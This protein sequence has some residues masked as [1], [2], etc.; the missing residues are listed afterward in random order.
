MAWSSVRAHLAGID[1]HVVKVAPA[2]ERVGDFRAFLGEAF[3]EA[4]TYA[5]LRQAESVGR[6]I[7]SKEWLADMETKTG[8]TLAARKRGPKRVDK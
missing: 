4:M 6:P 2:L 8:M 1:D 3:G 7:G 5:G